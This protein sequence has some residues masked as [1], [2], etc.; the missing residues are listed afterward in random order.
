MPQEGVIDLET[1]FSDRQQS[2]QQI[3]RYDR[4]LAK[5]KEFGGVMLRECGGTYSREITLAL[6]NLQ[7]ATFWAHAAIVANQTV[8]GLAGGAGAGMPSPI[9]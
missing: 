2:P 9:A 6:T 8:G 7:N 3:Q 4:V 5:A 1:A